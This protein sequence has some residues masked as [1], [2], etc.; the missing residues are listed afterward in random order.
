[1]KLHAFVSVHHLSLLLFA[2]CEYHSDAAE[3]YIHAIRCVERA[4]ASWGLWEGFSMA[5]GHAG[6]VLSFIDIPSFSFL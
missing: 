3:S 6:G 4:G 5:F 2:M 1:M